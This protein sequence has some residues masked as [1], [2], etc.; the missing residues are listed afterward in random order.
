VRM[1]VKVISSDKIKRGER[2]VNCYDCKYCGEIPGSAHKK[3]LY[4]LRDQDNPIINL[5]SLFG[6]LRMDIP[7]M[8]VVLIDTGVRRGWCSFPFNFDPIWIYDCD[9]FTPKEKET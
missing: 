7:R 2:K 5:L 3:C 6:G 9:K 1:P 8:T 4:A